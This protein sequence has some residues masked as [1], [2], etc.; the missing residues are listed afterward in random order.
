MEIDK[1]ASY[2]YAHLTDKQLKLNNM[3]GIEQ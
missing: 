3:T 2:T 1:A